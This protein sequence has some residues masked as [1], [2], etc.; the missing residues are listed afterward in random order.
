MLILPLRPAE[1]I[2]LGG[3]IKIECISLKDGRVLLGILAPEGM[4]VRIAQQPAGHPKTHEAGI[5]P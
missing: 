1:V 4:P 5:A 3:D 2:T